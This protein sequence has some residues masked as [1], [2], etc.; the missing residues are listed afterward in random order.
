MS[1]EMQMCVIISTHTRTHTSSSQRGILS[2]CER[3]SVFI[4]RLS[5]A[6]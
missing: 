3:V 6:H 5:V 4:V 2:V 1:S